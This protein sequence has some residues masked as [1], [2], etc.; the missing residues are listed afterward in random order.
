MIAPNLHHPT[1]VVLMQRRFQTMAAILHG[2]DSTSRLHPQSPMVTNEDDLVG[3]ITAEGLQAGFGAISVAAIDLLARF[4]SR[5]L[6][7]GFL[8][9][10]FTGLYR[11]AEGYHLLVTR[12]NLYGWTLTIRG[13]CYRPEFT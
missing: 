2:K 7:L 11:F 13:G 10:S 4:T 12:P 6:H 1:I 8:S 9:L 3:T 5:I